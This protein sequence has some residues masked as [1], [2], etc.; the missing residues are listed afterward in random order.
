MNIETTVTTLELPNLFLW[1]QAL[2]GLRKLHRV[3]LICQVLNR[4]AYF[5]EMIL[6]L[7]SYLLLHKGTDSLSHLVHVLNR[8]LFWGKSLLRNLILALNFQILIRIKSIIGLLLWLFLDIF[9]LVFNNWGNFNINFSVLIRFLCFWFM[10]WI[11]LNILNFLALYLRWLLNLYRV[12]RLL[13]HSTFL[14]I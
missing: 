8:L 2:F 4:G 3:H 5:Q 11:L 7:R 12:A 13:N 9:N 10:H 1:D 14:I 6:S